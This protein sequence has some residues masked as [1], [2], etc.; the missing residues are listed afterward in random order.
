VPGP[1]GEGVRVGLAAALHIAQ[2]AHADRVLSEGP[3][4]LLTEMLLDQHTR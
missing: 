2:D 4:A 3:F 1:R